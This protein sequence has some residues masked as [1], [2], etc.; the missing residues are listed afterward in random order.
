MKW[1]QFQ[2]FFCILL[3]AERPIHRG[4]VRGHRVCTTCPVE[5]YGQSLRS[6]ARKVFW[7]SFYRF[8]YALRTQIK[9][10]KR[11]AI[12]ASTALQAS[13]E[14]P[15]SRSNRR[16]AITSQRRN[17]APKVRCEYTNSSGPARRQ[18]CRQPI[19]KQTIRDENPVR[20]TIEGLGHRQGY[21]LI[22][23]ILILVLIIILIL[24]FFFTLHTVQNKK[25][26]RY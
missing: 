10:C 21:H 15:C 14:P 4:W 22:L 17:F 9:V 18:R 3:S 5:H 12:N 19:I 11:M 13:T 7:T 25:I 26:L 16:V 1:N 20:G 8:A 2:I 24:I 23:I 6:S